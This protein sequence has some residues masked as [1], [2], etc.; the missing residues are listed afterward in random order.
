MAYR[1]LDWPAIRRG[2]Q[3]YT[4]V[5]APCHPL[6]G[7]T[8]NHFQ[9][10]MTKEEIRT[11]AANYEVTDENPDDEGRVVVRPGKPTDYLPQPYPNQQAAQFANN[12]AEPPPLRIIF[13]AREGKAN[14]IFSLLTG[15]TWG[16]DLMPVP[17][18]AP[19]LKSGQFWNPYMPGCVIAM[20]PPLS[21]GQIEYEDGTP[22]TVSQMAKDVTSFLRWSAE[23]EYDDRKL[24][25]WKSY[26]T[27]ILWFFTSYYW[28]QKQSSWRIYQRLTFR[29]WKNTYVR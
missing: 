24:Y 29:Y 12:G 27:C 19:R 15:Y 20:P 13:H 11:L 10:F 5:F 6:E 9:Q 7:Y 3:I 26:T 8:F 14:Y 1:S 18:F 28:M 22:A 4:E 16:G 23:P 2:R 25:F 21:D 17:P